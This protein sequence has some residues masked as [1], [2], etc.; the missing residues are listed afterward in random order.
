ME[1]RLLRLTGAAIDKAVKMIIERKSE[2]ERIWYQ[3]LV[4]NNVI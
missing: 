4:S 3:V 1:E 2:T